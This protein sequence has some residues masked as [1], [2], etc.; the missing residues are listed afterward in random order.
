MTQNKNRGHTSRGL[1]NKFF[2]LGP[3]NPDYMFPLEIFLHFN[4]VEI[5][6]R[7]FL[8]ESFLSSE[9]QFSIPRMHS[10]PGTNECVLQR[11][12]ILPMH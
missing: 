1:E 2:C 4:I 9:P 11:S 7:I 8:R 12:F 5:S 10:V 3:I 6:S